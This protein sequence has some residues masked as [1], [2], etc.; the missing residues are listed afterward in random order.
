MSG[1]SSGKDGG[2][3]EKGKERA[4][5]ESFSESSQSLDG[6]LGA[7]EEKV[8]KLSGRIRDVVAE[9][10]RLRGELAGVEA[11]RDRLAKELGQL[12][13]AHSRIVDDAEKLSRYEAERDSMRIRI[14]RL[15]KTLGDAESEAD[16]PGSQG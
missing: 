5:A 7:L 10:A 1:R 11:A 6:Y 9:N 15:L 3:K 2:D 12:T 14:D 8:E 4:A 16:R 13:E